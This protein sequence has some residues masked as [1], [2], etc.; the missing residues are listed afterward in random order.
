MAGGAAVA[1][2]IGDVGGGRRGRDGDGEADRGGGRRR[3]RVELQRS[4]DFKYTQMA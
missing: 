4:R 2:R 1:A 3:R